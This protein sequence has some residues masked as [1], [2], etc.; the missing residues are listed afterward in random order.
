MLL[1]LL[2]I[3]C[4]GGETVVV[5]EE[6]VVTS[7]IEKEVV[8]E[9]EVP[10]VVEKEVEVV[11]EVAVEK[12]VKV[13]VEVEKVVQATAESQAKGVEVEQKKYG[14]TL[15]VVS[16]ASIES[17]DISFTGAWVTTVVNAHI[18]DRLFE[19]DTEL[20]S[21]PQMVDTWSVSSDGRTWLFT[22]RDGLKFHNGDPVT[23]ADVIPSLKRIWVTQA[24]GS[25]MNSYLVAD[26]MQAVTDNTFSLEF[27]RSMGV[28]LDGLA[29]PW[30]FSNIYPKAIGEMEAQKDF[31]EE[32]A[33]GSG[34]Y[35]LKNWEKGN[36]LVLERFEDYIP[37]AES[38]SYLSGGKKAYLD[39][40]EWL[41]VPAEE[42]KIAGLETGEWDLVDGAGLDFYP[43]IKSNPDMGIAEDRNH[44]SDFDFNL[45][46]EPA[47]N[48]G[49]RQAILAASDVDELMAGIG[50]KE[51]WFKTAARY[52]NSPYHTE[53]GSEYY[54]QGDMAKAQQILAGSGYN[55]ETLLLMNPNDYA[56]ITFLGEVLKPMIE[57]I[58][59]TV[60]MPGMDWATLLSRLPDPD[61]DIITD[62]WVQWIMADPVMDPMPSCSL[63][64]GN[65]G[66][67]DG[68]QIMLANREKFA[69][70]TDPQEQM[71]YVEAIQLQLYTDVPHVFLG[72]W[73]AIYPYRDY[74]KN[75]SVPIMPVFVNVWLEK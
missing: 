1:S 49:V 52:Y 57:E 14:G 67:T 25:F 7:V 32:N 17:L 71:K 44:I 70:A 20:K 43:R 28:V 64:F 53:V 27:D 61:W 30:P 26:G 15:R 36:K 51:L 62:W 11:K 73:S 8:V 45:I 63:Y 23:S 18:W 55:G 6:V 41:E 24:H 56:T 74:V 68:C 69:F 9:K 19:R 66:K 21:L 48:I 60:D 39:R 2:A 4:G 59:I 58:G 34:P 75:F 33:I 42:T 35:K 46:S 22:L 29:S 72:W 13:T 47:N 12:V 40:I 37:R 54:D 50:P 31:G 38:G 16:Q 3:A 65:W 5:K 10:V